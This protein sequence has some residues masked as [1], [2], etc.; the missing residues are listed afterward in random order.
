MKAIGDLLA[1]AAFDSRVSSTIEQDMWEKWF[2][3]AAAGAA[4]VLL[5]GIAG[6]VSAVDGGPELVK[7]VVAESAAV[8]DAEGHRA[9]DG[10]RDRVVGALTTPGS[11]FV[12]YLYRDFRA[13]R[14]TEVEPILG[15]LY[16]RA[17]ARGIPTPLLAAAT[18]RLRVHETALDAAAS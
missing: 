8:L 9:R 3:M 7:Q 1:G 13:G 15:E 6:A 18:V 10:A 5:G 16:R 14:R 12:T 11:A 2:F 17:A 4:T